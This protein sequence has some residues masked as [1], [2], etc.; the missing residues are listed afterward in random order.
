[1]QVLDP[2]LK[3]RRLPCGVVHGLNR[4]VGHGWILVKV[5]D[6]LAAPYEHKFEVLAALLLD[7]GLGE[8]VA[9]DDPR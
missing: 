1:M 9:G 7:D 4:A 5:L 8:A 3:P 6:A 2:S